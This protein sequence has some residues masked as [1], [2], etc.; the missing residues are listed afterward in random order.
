M[1]AGSQVVNSSLIG[2]SLTTSSTTALFGLG[3]RAMGGG[4]EWEYVFSSATMATGRICYISPDGTALPV[5]TGNVAASTAGMKLGVTQFLMSAGE[6]GF[7]ATYGG[8]IYIACSG[9][10]PP[11]VQV[12]FSATSGVL[13]TSLAAAAGNTAAGFFITT[14]ASTATVSV[15]KGF[16]TYP[17]ALVATVTPAG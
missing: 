6:Y 11:T 9:T 1:A 4:A 7:V 5:T 17:R 13:V 8:E 12:A 16:I 2:A 15:A 14:S 10:V 3:T